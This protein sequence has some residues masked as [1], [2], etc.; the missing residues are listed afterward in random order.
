MF[1]EVNNAVSGG[2]KD[3]DP[4]FDGYSNKGDADGGKEAE[5]SPIRGLVVEGEK[6]DD[7]GGFS[8]LKW[9]T[10]EI[11]NIGSG[12]VLHQ[13]L[14][15][16]FKSNTF[17]HAIIIDC[18][19]SLLNRMEELRDVGSVSRVFF[20]TNFLKKLLGNYL[21]TEN[22]QNSIAFN[23][24][25]ARVMKMTWKVEKE[26]S[27]CGVYLMRHMESYMGENEGRWDCGFTGKNRLI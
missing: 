23:K 21:K 10:E 26:G 1:K 6:K 13:V 9:I 11:W 2:I 4:S 24:I 18:W 12:H 27:D 8:N 25:K 14:T 3:K 22:Y 20:D 17:I 15:Y 5:F 16:H 7:G 19:S